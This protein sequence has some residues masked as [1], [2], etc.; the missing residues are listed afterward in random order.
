MTTPTTEQ[1]QALF[2]RPVCIAQQNP[3]EHLD[4][5]SAAERALT[6]SMGSRRIHGFSAGRVAAREALRKLGIEGKSV[7][8]GDKR[9]PIWPAAVSGSISHC[10]DRCL[11]A[12]AWR[13]DIAGLGVDVEQLKVLSEGVQNM[14]LTA[15]E[16]EQL[17]TLNADG[18]DPDTWPC[19]IFSIK[20]SLY[21]CLNPLTKKW[22]D[23][24]QANIKLSPKIGSFDISLAPQAHDDR[25]RMG[26]LTGRFL[27]TEGHVY[28]AVCLTD[29]PQSSH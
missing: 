21:K 7:L 3:G 4:L 17:S 19:V 29:L 6:T 2:A 18:V 22:I 8:I 9:R 28:S 5:L 20:E 25:T 13:K 12:V 15:A 11:A 14:I 23:F 27:C 10:K 1:L 24:H 26:C 16:K